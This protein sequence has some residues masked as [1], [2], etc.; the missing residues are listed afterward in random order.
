MIKLYCIPGGGTPGATFY[1]WTSKLSKKAE[2]IV[3]EYPGRGIRKKEPSF[4]T[5]EETAYD[6]Y[7]KIKSDIK[8]NKYM[9]L[10]SCTGSYVEYELYSLIAKNGLPIPERMFVFSSESPHSELYKGRDYISSENKDVLLGNYVSFFK[11]ANILFP[12]KAAVCY[13]DALIK[14][15]AAGKSF[16]ERSVLSAYGALDFEQEM[17]ID[18]ADETVKMLADDWLQA[19][20]YTEQ[21]KD[22]SPVSCPITFVYG[23]DD[24]SFN[25]KNIAEWKNLAA[26][27]FELIQAEGDHEIM[28]NSPIRCM[29]IVSEYL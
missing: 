9:L 11:K 7:E 12:E 14:I 26:G 27:G 10:S 18:F 20:R 24:T 15:D 6:M 8:E 13:V 25:E 4:D 29:E 2:I 16:P 1:K 28:I 5:V 19:R 23:T 17:M 21:N 22:R 3:L